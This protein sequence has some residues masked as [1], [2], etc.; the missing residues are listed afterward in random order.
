MARRIDNEC[1]YCAEEFD[2]AQAIIGNDRKVYCCEFCAQQGEIL[3][4]SEKARIYLQQ[5]PLAA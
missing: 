3:S 5:Y 2:E 1:A 4:E